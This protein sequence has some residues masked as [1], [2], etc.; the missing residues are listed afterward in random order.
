M[1]TSIFCMVITILVTGC[2]YH[3]DQTIQNKFKKKRSFDIYS[4]S[5]ET[6]RYRK[7]NGSCPMVCLFVSQKP[8]RRLQHSCT[9]ARGSINALPQA[10]KGCRQ[11]LNDVLS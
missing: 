10:G 1:S 5:D 2:L 6:E 9:V 8:C 7:T 3:P 11:K 4:P